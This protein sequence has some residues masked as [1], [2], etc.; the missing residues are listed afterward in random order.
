MALDYPLLIHSVFRVGKRLRGRA[1][2]FHRIFYPPSP[3][4]PPPQ[5]MYV[6]Y[7]SQAH[8]TITQ[9]RIYPNSE[10]GAVGHPLLMSMQTSDQYVL[11]AHETALPHCPFIIAP[12]ASVD[13]DT[14][15]V[16]VQF[17]VRRLGELAEYM[18]HADYVQRLMS[19]VVKRAA[20]LPI[21]P[22]GSGTYLVVELAETIGAPLRSS[23]FPM[24]ARVEEVDERG[25]ATA[26][27]FWVG[28]P[29]KLRQGD[30]LWRQLDPCLPEND[31][32]RTVK[33]A[34]VL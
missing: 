31:R 14:I 12:S 5:E 9:A 24:I 15:S 21:I 7:P 29:P 18:A 25:R 33:I 3:A 1:L 13:V 4:H 27:I 6:V 32:C 17:H 23:Q 26:T 16:V 22:V 30:E 10:P 20:E 11:E 2:G 8:I 34:T 19:A 28:E